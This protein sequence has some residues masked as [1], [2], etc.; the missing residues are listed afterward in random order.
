[1]NLKPIKHKPVIC[2]YVF[3][4]LTSSDDL[5]KKLENGKW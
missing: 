5:Y 1:M 4:I 2:V 3:E